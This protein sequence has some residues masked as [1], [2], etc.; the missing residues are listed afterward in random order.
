MAVVTAEECADK[1]FSKMM[2]IADQEEECPALTKEEWRL[3]KEHETK[4]ELEHTTTEVRDYLKE[5]RQQEEEGK[6]EEQKVEEKSRQQMPQP[7]PLQTPVTAKD[8]S[9]Q[10]PKR[11]TLVDGSTQAALPP[12][13][14]AQQ[15]DDQMAQQQYGQ[16][17]EPQEDE[18]L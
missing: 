4:A 1:V 18:Q 6:H 9:W 7:W 10:T 11:P 12:P 17:A 16:E 3:V 15:D 13:P 8:N 5:T 14:M 2:A